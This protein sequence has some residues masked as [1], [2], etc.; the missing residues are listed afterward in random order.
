LRI[1]TKKLTPAAIR[2]KLSNHMEDRTMILELNLT[3][4][5]EN[6]LR[7]SAAGSGQDIATFVRQVVTELID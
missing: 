6:L 5:V 4:D 7:Q 3:A 1:E 2:G